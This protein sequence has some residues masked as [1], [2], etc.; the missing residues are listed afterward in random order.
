MTT[1]M[2]NDGIDKKNDD[3]CVMIMMIKPTE[4]GGHREW[5]K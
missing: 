1:R 5:Q 4:S 3:G 2:L